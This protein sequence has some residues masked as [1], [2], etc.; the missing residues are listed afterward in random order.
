MQGW[1]FVGLASRGV[2]EFWSNQA[3]SAEGPQP[4]ARICQMCFIHLGAFA[5]V[6]QR[7]GGSCMK[8]ARRVVPTR[9]LAPI[10]GTVRRSSASRR[11]ASPSVSFRAASTT[12][13]AR[14]CRQ[15][16]STA[17][18]TS[19][20]CPCQDGTTGMRDAKGN[21]QFYCPSALAYYPPRSRR[22]FV[23]RNSS[24]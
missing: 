15:P 16:L 13:S 19:R 17:A 4:T 20:I 21:L 2:L 11:D 3:R 5:L 14:G 8:V 23:A 10:P 9:A 24:L 1:V 6:Q 7:F 22:A 12:A 18:A